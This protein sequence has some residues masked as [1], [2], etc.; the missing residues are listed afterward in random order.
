MSFQ[1]RFVQGLGGE[2]QAHP[3]HL[4]GGI[5]LVITL[6]VLGTQAAS[7]GV[8][9]DDDKASCTCS[10]PG[11]IELARTDNKPAKWFSSVSAPD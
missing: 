7:A 8:E 6:L 5:L 2:K 4:L 1:H 10:G 3:P 11:I 9:C